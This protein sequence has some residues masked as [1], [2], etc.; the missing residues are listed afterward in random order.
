MEWSTLRVC[1]LLFGGLNYFFK[2]SFAIGSCDIPVDS[3]V[4][5]G[6]TD[7]GKTTCDVGQLC[8]EVGYGCYFRT[9]EVIG[10]KKYIDGQDCAGSDIGLYVVS[11]VKECSRICLEESQCAAYVMGMPRSCYLKTDCKSY[12]TSLTSYHRIADKRLTCFIG[13]YEGSAGTAFGYFQKETVISDAKNQNK[14]IA[15]T[16]TGLYL[17][18]MNLNEITKDY[19]K[20]IC[21]YGNFIFD[22]KLGTKTVSKEHKFFDN[23]EMTCE[24][25]GKMPIT[26]RFPWP[27]VD[28]SLS[29]FKVGIKGENLICY[30]GFQGKEMNGIIVYLPLD[31]QIN[32][33]F[34]G[35]FIA[36]NLILASPVECQY[37]CNCGDDFCQAFYSNINDKRELMKVCEIETIIGEAKGSGHF[38]PGQFGPLL[39]ISAHFGHFGPEHFGPF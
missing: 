29:Q 26:V 27:S 21:F 8:H 32:S 25:I 31:H 4:K 17:K 37:N 36:C 24:T 18:K 7:N 33:S 30:S 14:A 23:D 15:F 34:N 22:E 2:C 19:D 39:D 6:D 35:N 16:P 28:N 1:A 13:G 20:N 12:Y 38:G 3:R 9:S 11:T 10:F 5:V